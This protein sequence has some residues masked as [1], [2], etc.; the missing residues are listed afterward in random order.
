MLNR[1]I[2]SGADSLQPPSYENSVV[3][4]ESGSGSS[5]LA[6]NSS[7]KQKKKNVPYRPSRELQQ[8]IDLLSN[9]KGNKPVTKLSSVSSN[10]H[11]EYF[12]ILP[13]FEMFQ[14]ILKRDDQQFQED[15]ST[16]PPEYGDTT[17][18]RPSIPASPRIFPQQSI[19]RNLA[20]VSRRLEHDIELQRDRLQSLNAFFNND[21]GLSPTISTSE[22][23]G[24]TAAHNDN[25]AV[26]Y[27]T[28]GDS[29][30]DNIDRLQKATNPHID[31]Q[32]YVTKGIPQPNAENDL[33]TKL[34]EYTSGDHVNGYVIVKNTAN[35]PVKFGLFT[36]S[37]EGT[38]KS[39][40]RKPNSSNR[41]YSKILMKKF[42]KMYDLSA[43]YSYGYL[44]S[45]AGIE[46][47]PFSKDRNDGCEI[48][49]PDSRVLQPQQRY[50]KFFTFK[51]PHRL[52]DNVCQDSIL[53]HLLPPPSMG[54]DK[55]SFGNRSEGIVLNKALGYGS[56]NL[57]GTPVVTRDYGFDDLSISYAIEAKIIDKVNS[58]DA[59]SHEE[60]NH[61]KHQD[62]VLS[63]HAQYFLRF[64]PQITEQLEYC[65]LHNV[66]N[67]S[68]NNIGEK[69]LDQF[70]L[71]STW[72]VINEENQK[73]DRFI[74][75]H[76]SGEVS[77]ED[78][79]LK[80]SVH[81]MQSPTSP[82]VPSSSSS[83]SSLLPL[84]SPSPSPSPLLFPTVSKHRGKEEEAKHEVYVST[85][86]PIEIFG[87]KKQMILSSQVKIGESTMSV[88]VP[89][90]VVQY[91]VPKLLMKYNMDSIGS[92]HDRDYG[93]ML[94]H[95]DIILNFEGDSKPQISSIDVNI[96]IWSYSTE[97]PLPFEM[98]YDFFY[99][100]HNGGKP[101][102]DPTETTKDNL[103]YLKDQVSRYIDFI[104]NN[105]I[106]VTKES[107]SYL[108][109][110]QKLGVKKDIIYNYFKPTSVSD[111]WDVYQQ[112]VF[113]WSQKI[114][115]PLIVDNKRNINLLPSFQ[116]CLVGR[117]YCL[118]IAVKFKGTH[119]EQ[120]ELAHN[121]VK[122][123]V[124]VLVG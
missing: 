106:D 11:T 109:S 3:G 120:V 2:D 40:E 55:T 32:I 58:K 77:L 64:I 67:Y 50:K 124:P 122:V 63:K 36:V 88:K 24:A 60:L 33:E 89:N 42:L 118:Q 66:G 6:S 111:N 28:S 29:P 12:D 19:D 114:R 45:S 105:S 98:G 17:H 43:S 48:G 9:T 115:V 27:D 26:T 112:K 71:N 59:V 30:L 116:S 21:V 44:P 79:K 4:G 16:S 13:S 75:Q 35:V 68:E 85:I 121:V 94:K 51:F 34:K 72:R 52:L 62:Y 49:L 123:D 37:L 56:L 15:L 65:E 47:E 81:S 95:V 92:T 5:R 25:V 119:N 39:L 76:F 101:S 22:G 31:I 108:K 20:E 96:V 100:N 93:N 41:K 7:R 70:R 113:R 83:S 78:L 87:K 84:P 74:D 38:V 82:P 54:V 69:F 61:A 1:S 23:A 46:Y 117:L 73:I 57:R 14:S 8:Q 110:A 104:R 103:Q 91:S 102:S 80:N 86:S 53:P 99:K 10:A 90:G 18:S 107:F 97:Y